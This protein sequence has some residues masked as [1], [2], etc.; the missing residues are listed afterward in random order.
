ML[1]VIEKTYSI[2]PMNQNSYI[3]N[4]LSK[5]DV[6]PQEEL[7]ALLADRNSKKSFD[8]IVTH[9]IKLVS[10]FL[11]Q[12]SHDFDGYK[13]SYEDLFQSGIEGLIVAVNKFDASNGNCFSTYAKYWIRQRI[14]Q[15]LNNSNYHAKVPANFKQ[16][17][18]KVKKFVKN[19]A[20]YE[21][22]IEEISEDLGLNKG[23][24]EACLNYYVEK[25]TVYLDA[26]IFENESD[27]DNHDIIP[28]NSDFVKEYEK[29]EA[30]KEIMKILPQI[31]KS[32]RNLDIFLEYHLSEDGISLSELG[33]KYDMSHER[34][35]QIIDA[36]MNQIIAK[37]KDVNLASSL[38]TLKK[39]S[40]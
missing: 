7:Q 13:T 3:Q 34:A 40:F 12:I 32:K 25:K 24:V 37:L 26:A 23:V 9:N 35:R 2:H 16:Y 27:F 17:I 38:K 21:P 30:F 20:P 10:F 6:L 39:K 18:D 5:Y 14:F 36:T 15:E 33:A 11:N 28:D 22:T 8:K 29:T 4:M 31:I 1:T 19:A